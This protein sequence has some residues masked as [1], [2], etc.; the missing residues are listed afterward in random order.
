MTH[1]SLG[2]YGH[3]SVT[4]GVGGVCLGV[5]ESW[6]TSKPH[7]REKSEGF[8]TIESGPDGIAFSTVYDTGRTTSPWPGPVLNLHSK[9]RAIFLPHY[10]ILLAVALPWVGLLIWRSRRIGHATLRPAE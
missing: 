2:R 8:T 4:Q 1:F 7:W 6:I 3:V 10:L 9:D 5:H